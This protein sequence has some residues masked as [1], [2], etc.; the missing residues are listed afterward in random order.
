VLTIIMTKFAS[1]LLSLFVLNV[2]LLTSST[3]LIAGAQGNQNKVESQKVRI[4][5]CFVNVEV[6]SI[7]ERPTNEIEEVKLKTTIEFPP[8]T[9]KVGYIETKP[10]SSIRGTFFYPET[11]D[12]G[13]AKQFFLCI[14]KSVT[15]RQPIQYTLKGGT[16]NTLE[17]S[18]QIKVRLKGTWVDA[19]PNDFE[20]ST[21]K[22]QKPSL[23]HWK[24]VSYKEGVDVLVRL[25]VFSFTNGTETG[26][27]DITEEIFVLKKAWFLRL[28]ENQIF[29][30]VISSLIG[31]LVMFFL[32]KSRKD[33]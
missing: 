26:K 19:P 1:V 8:I 30:A 13:R 14:C 3:N 10:D 24:V 32:G 22:S 5:S 28:P 25:D 11:M 31:G 27:G 18:H 4:Q 15:D 12:T 17:D 20:E 23:I 6:V 33:S 2:G 7:K 29:I 21:V 16:S 9:Y